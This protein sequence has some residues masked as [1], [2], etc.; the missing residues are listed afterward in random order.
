M[1]KRYFAI[2]LFLVSCSSSKIDYDYDRF[3]DF[4]K[5]KSYN[6]YPELDSGM[7]ELDDKRLMNQLDS[8]L[9]S[10]GFIKKDNPD[11][12]VNFRAT[13]FEGASPFS[14]NLGF[15]SIGRSGGV[16]VSGGTPVGGASLF[17]VLFFDIV[18]AN[19]NEL[20]WQAR[21][22]KRIPRETTPLKREHYFLSVVSDV[23]RKFPPENSK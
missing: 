16:G 8:V 22:E 6:Y 23:F 9:Q 1:K 2:F 18:E 15:G 5:F 14:V 4:N 10:K 7:N 17:E 20:I 13:R 12:F 11:L 19:L 3:L 21:S